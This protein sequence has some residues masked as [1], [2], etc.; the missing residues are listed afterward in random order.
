[1]YQPIALATGLMTINR[2]LMNR[3]SGVAYVYT[4]AYF[5]PGNDRTNPRNSRL[6][7]SEANRPIGI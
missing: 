6:S 7:R 3:F 1:M 5:F 4:T 2:M